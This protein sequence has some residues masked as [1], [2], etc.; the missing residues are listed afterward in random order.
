MPER[1]RKV[2]LTVLGCGTVSLEPD[3]AC[4]GFHVSTDRQDLLMD[5]GG[6]VLLRM[7]QAGLDHMAVNTLLLSHIAHPDHVS[8]VPLLLFAWN[9]NPSGGRTAAATVLGPPGTGDFLRAVHDLYPATAP[10]EYSLEIRELAAG[11][12][13]LP[14]LRIVVRTMRHG[15][16]P[17][18]GYRLETARAAL[19]YSGD[20]AFC[21]AL[22]EICRSA[23]LALVDC[24]FPAGQALYDSHLTARDVGRLAAESAPHA[25]MI[26]H[27]YPVGSPEE[28]ARQIR[29]AYD[30][31]L[32][33]ATDLLSV[34]LPLDGDDTG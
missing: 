1:K 20:T 22:V 33:T 3:K 17:A 26:T 11:E 29:E 13:S 8:D 15:R 27:C 30:G 14:G 7:R 5:C 2:K 28:T 12:F 25:V 4:S 31:P 16:V 6:G 10:R 9:Y 32:L 23:D 21:P 18:V 34:C 19:A 24:S